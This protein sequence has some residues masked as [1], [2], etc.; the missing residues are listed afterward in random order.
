MLYRVIWEID[1]DADTPREAAELARDFQ[2][3]P[4][5]MATVYTVESYKDSYWEREDTVTIDLSETD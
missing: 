2:R 1:L 4:D 5:T 3:N